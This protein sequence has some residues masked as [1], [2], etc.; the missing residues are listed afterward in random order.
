MLDGYGPIP[1]ALARDLAMSEEATWR[2]LV[3]D[4]LSGGLLDAGRATYR[5]PATLDRFVRLRDQVCR[6][7]GCHRSARLAD[8]DHTTRFPDGPTAA[9]NTAALCRFHH[10]LKHHG[11][12]HVQT[13]RDPQRS[14]HLPRAL[15]H[16][17]PV[18]VWTSP[19]GHTHA[20]RAHRYEE[21]PED[22]GRI[23][24]ARP[25]PTE[26]AIHAILRA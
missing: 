20:T 2:R 25:S 10:R 21:L 7:P 13:V 3:T 5:P 15:Q 6:F 11:G 24:A 14:T 9:H 19:T 12:W 16:P 22:T 26:A 1:A 23:S 4:P 8:I 18:M 17:A